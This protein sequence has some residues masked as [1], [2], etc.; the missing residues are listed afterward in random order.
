MTK[1][2][3][4][5]SPECRQPN[6]AISE[7]HLQ[8]QNAACVI[9]G[10]CHRQMPRNCMHTHSVTTIKLRCF[11]AGGAAVAPGWPGQDKPT[12][13]PRALE[14]LQQNCR[15]QPVSQRDP[16]LARVKSSGSMRAETR[17]CSIL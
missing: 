12:A 1:A 4:R 9:P 15:Y 14:A 5:L 10:C 6:I 11:T 13:P 2:G 17:H 3:Q 16:H 7:S 8:M